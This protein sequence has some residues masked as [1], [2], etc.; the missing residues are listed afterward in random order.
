MLVLNRQ[1]YIIESTIIT[2]TG[3]C[4]LFLFP[5]LRARLSSFII[6]LL[7]SNFLDGCLQLLHVSTHD[8]LLL[9]LAILVQDESGHSAHL[10]F[11]CHRTDLINVDLNEAHIGVG[12]AELADHWR[13][14]LARTAPGCEEVDDHGTVGGKRLEDNRARPVSSQFTVYG[15]ELRRL[16]YQPQ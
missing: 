9:Q 8:A 10:Q 3:A 13:D 12:F 7:C 15:A 1:G 14:G 5:F 6:T 2:W 16:T 11:L 4:Y